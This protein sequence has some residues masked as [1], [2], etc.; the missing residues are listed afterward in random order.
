MHPLSDPVLCLLVHLFICQCQAEL[1][2]KE[3]QEVRDAQS[4]VQLMQQ[5]VGLSSE[6][7][8]L[9]LALQ[10]AETERLQVAEDAKTVSIALQNIEAE[11][12][13]GF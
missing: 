6:R 10:E 9:S 11:L 1:A 7:D 13:F 8:T 3:Q 4:Q 5:V 12:M 2:E